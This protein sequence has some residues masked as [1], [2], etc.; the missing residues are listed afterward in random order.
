MILDFIL[1][2]LLLVCLTLL[3]TRKKEWLSGLV[4]NSLVSGILL[5]AIQMMML[6]G[7]LE[8][9]DSTESI[10]SIFLIKLIIRLRP[11]MIGLIYKFIFQIV[12]QI[13]E[14]KKT[15]EK[16]DSQDNE[17][18]ESS[19]AGNSFDFSLLS[20]REIEVARLAA[21]GYTNAQIAEYMQS[22]KEQYTE[23]VQRELSKSDRT[24]RG[25]VNR[26][27][28]SL[29]HSPKADEI[30]AELLEALYNKRDSKAVRIHA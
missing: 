8:K 17:S 1:V 16:S 2:T 29:S 26:T 23:A 5:S 11:L 9:T 7:F 18:S 12:N 13:V 20:R 25:K 4:Q 14:N 19:V 6:A 10:L 22:H 3:T 30:R 28:D 15:E 27:F 21:K 24:V